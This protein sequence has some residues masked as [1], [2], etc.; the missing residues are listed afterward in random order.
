MIGRG[1]GRVTPGEEVEVDIT[2]WRA[3]HGDSHLVDLAELDHSGDRSRD[4]ER[5]R[6]QVDEHQH[7]LRLD[8][9][10]PSPPPWELIEPPPDNE[11]AG[12]DAY[13]TLRLGV[14][15][16][17]P[18]HPLVPKS[19]YYFGPP[20]VTSAY[21]SDPIGQIGVHYPRE[22]L[23]I[24]RDYSGGEL[25]QFSLAYPLELEGRITPTKFLETMNAINETLI[26]AHS[27]RH[28]FLDNFLAV[29]SLQISRLFFSSHYDKEMLRLK[30]LIQDINANI[31]NPRGLNIMWPRKVAF[32]FLEIEYYV[33]PSPP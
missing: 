12:T 2:A 22:I 3:P 11:P 17:L 7:P 21:G 10:P 29:F 5:E 32:L 25:I 24:E 6:E 8:I 15:P 16:T 14:E 9:N 30:E 23:R 33:S 4:G 28:A 13:S 31:Y 19:S 26:S 27:T 1:G 20:P 18:P